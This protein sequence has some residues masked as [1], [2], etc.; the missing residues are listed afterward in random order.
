M[1]EKAFVFI[2]GFGGFSDIWKWQLAS[3]SKEARC[4]SIDLPGH[5]QAPWG[6]QTLSDMADALCIFLAVHDVSRPVVIASSFGGLVVL[7][8]LEEC[9]ALAERLIL[10][11]SSPRFT[12]DKDYPA[13]LNEAKIRKLADQFKG[14]TS[15]VL[16]MFFRSLFTRVERES[17][18]YALIKELRAKAPLPSRDA[19]LVMLDILE[20]EDLRNVLGQV[21]I[22]VHF[23][24]GEDDPICPTTLMGPL[25]ALC[26]SATMDVVKNSGH[27]PFLSYPDEFNCLVRGY[28]KV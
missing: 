9:P 14:D 22:P 13:G 20:K 1:S 24:F 28:V 8:A 19:L 21:S 18:Q 4:L 5:G 12:S 25:K 15:G 2:H 11:G 23:I 17:P 6:D 26:P 27:F 16:D 3:L 7:K 10:V